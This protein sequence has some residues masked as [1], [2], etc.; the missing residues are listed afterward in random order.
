[1]AEINEGAIIAGAEALYTAGLEDR[2]YQEVSEIV[3]KGAAPKLDSDG[4]HT[5]NELYR[6]RAA[7]TAVL[8]YELAPLRRYDVHKSWR[9]SDGELCFGGDWFIVVAQLPAGQISY[10]YPATDWEMFRI[11]E[12]DR[13]FEFD[14]HTPDDVVAR[15]ESYVRG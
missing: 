15:L 5:F 2:T 4:F 13:A 8:L 11:P 6:H 7:L 10:H 9:H 14:G 1:M 3:L 12:R